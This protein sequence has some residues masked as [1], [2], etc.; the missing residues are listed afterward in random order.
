MGGK[1]P[2]PQTILMNNGAYGVETF[3]LT[4]RIIVELQLSISK[5]AFVLWGNS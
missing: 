3:L 2:S 1:V 4:E 5:V